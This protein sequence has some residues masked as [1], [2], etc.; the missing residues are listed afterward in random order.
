MSNF[1]N[2]YNLLLNWII[3]ITTNICFTVAIIYLWDAN[4]DEIVNDLKYI[5]N[6]KIRKI[7]ENISLVSD[8]VHEIRERYHLINK[9]FVTRFNEYDDLFKEIMT[10]QESIISYMELIDEKTLVRKS[11]LTIVGE[12]INDLEKDVV[13][14]ED[15]MVTISNS[16]KNLQEI[17]AS[18]A[19]RQSIGEN[20][21]LKFRS[22]YFKDRDYDYGISF[23][24]SV[25]TDFNYDNNNNN[26]I[27]INLNKNEKIDL[28][29][30]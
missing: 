29:S 15:D 7:E 3:V 9:S 25:L 5:I 18:I 19:A 28:I 10:N 8:N 12:D 11:E 14:L 6:Q 27:N 1:E 24:E 26:N 21:K 17:V 20:H 30:V 4:N 16:V 13:C 23:E 22:E 2:F